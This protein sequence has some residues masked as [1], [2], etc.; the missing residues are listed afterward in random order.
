MMISVGIYAIA[1]NFKHC[2]TVTIYTRISA[3][4]FLLLAGEEEG[5]DYY[6]N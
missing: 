2:I 3:L 4:L 1:W 6:E 5:N